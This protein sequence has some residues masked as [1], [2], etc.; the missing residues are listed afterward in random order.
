MDSGDQ[1]EI[2]MYIQT[3]QFRVSRED[4]FYPKEGLDSI[5]PW[6]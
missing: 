1:L 6:Q 4:K 3:S 5:N 2:T